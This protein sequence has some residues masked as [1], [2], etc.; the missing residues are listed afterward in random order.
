MA[1]TITK[2]NFK[3]VVLK[4]DKPVLVDF[5]ATWC[6][7]CQMQGPIVDQLASEVKDLAVVAKLNVD[8]QQ[9]LAAE[10]KVMSIPT[11]VVFKNGKIVDH[12][13]GVHSKEDLRKML[14]V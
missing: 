7:P 12:A 10:Y 13:V 9:E 5:W 3:E 2:E 11:L 1:I 4:S 14:G 6:R 8:D